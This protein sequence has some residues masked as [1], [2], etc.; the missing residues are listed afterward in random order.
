MK[1]AAYYTA[2]FGDISLIFNEQ[3]MLQE[4]HLHH[5]FA[6]SVIGLP[7]IWQQKLDAYFSGS[8]KQFDIAPSENGTP[9]QRKVWEAIACIPYGKTVSYRDIA[10]ALGSH[11]RAVGGACGKNPLALVIP[12]HRVVAQRGL[13]GF[14]SGVDT[15]QAL[16]VKKWL[17]RH[18]GAE[19]FDAAKQ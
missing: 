3:M 7:E 11:P 8:L 17:L 2:P 4:L 14:S 6:D 15:D 19:W 18:E 12:C 13:G 10:L 16:A 1:L 9:F 5:V